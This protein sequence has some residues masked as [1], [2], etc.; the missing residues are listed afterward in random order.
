MSAV[1]GHLPLLMWRGYRPT[2]RVVV[3]NVLALALTVAACVAL[4]R[5][6]GALAAVAAW[7]VGH[8]LW[9]L[10]LRALVAA[11]SI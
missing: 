8:L 1:L 3:E 9:G 4:G 10:R 11:N 7:A 6:F 2:R 5:A